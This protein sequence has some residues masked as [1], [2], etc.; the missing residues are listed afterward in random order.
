MTSQTL[1]RTVA[2]R[3]ASSS[4]YAL[5]A[6]ASKRGSVAAIRRAMKST[7]SSSA[8]AASAA[9]PFRAS[10]SISS[11][12]V[13][14]TAA[15]AAEDNSEDH[16][17]S[18]SLHHHENETFLTG[19]ASLYAEQMYEMYQSNPENVHETWRTYFDNLDEGIAYDETNFQSPTV[20]EGAGGMAARTTQSAQ[21]AGAPSDSLG[22]SHLIRAYQVNGHS[23]AQIDPLGLHTKESFPLRPEPVDEDGYPEDLTPSFHGFDPNKDMDRKLNFRGTHS[24]GNKGYLEE[25]SARPGKVTLRG[26]VDQLRK[27]YCG[28][29]A[30]EYMHISDVNKCNWIRERI[31]TPRWLAY[32]KEKQL[33]I[34]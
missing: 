20:L 16:S 19:S 31:E 29:L 26:I 5:S 9:E 7:S 13:L 17:S 11:R 34:F 2:R 30:V 10:S 27:T 21:M 22:V 12:R 28:T 14:S 8:A 4:S 18:S 23:A 24:G 15:A 25:L 6:S 32:D 1:L 33:H 3:A